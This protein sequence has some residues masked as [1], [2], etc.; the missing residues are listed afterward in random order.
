MQILNIKVTKL[1][2]ELKQSLVANF[3]NL[4]CDAKEKPNLIYREYLKYKILHPHS[5]MATIDRKEIL[6]E[7]YS[8]CHIESRM[9]YVAATI[10][11]FNFVRNVFS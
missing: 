5:D 11:Y 8:S 2:E 4:M 7:I 3:F 9:M 10:G 1:D 6:E